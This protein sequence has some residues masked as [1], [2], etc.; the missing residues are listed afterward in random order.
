M[1]DS[2]KTI[3][4]RATK[5]DGEIAIE[6]PWLNIIAGT[7]PGWLKDNFP[8]ILI[9]GGLA[10]RIIFVYEETKR[11]LIAYPER[12]QLPKDYR[13]EE[14]A[15]LYD[16]TQIANIAGEYKLSEAAYDWGTNWYNKLH[17][18]RKANG[19]LAVERWQGYLSRK[20]AL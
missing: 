6:N 15:L 12:L 19:S 5:Q 2:Q 14:E 13:M 10:S 4:G 7:T 18:E 8:R 20:Q 9:E 17:G 1:W 11:Q 3:Y 16:L